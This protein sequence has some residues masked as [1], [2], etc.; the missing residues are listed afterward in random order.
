MTE[1]WDDDDGARAR[2]GTWLGDKYRLDRVLG[3]GGM[4]IVFS[5]MHRNTKRV[6]VKMLRP[7]MKTHADT[8]R[9][10]LREGYVANTVDHP[11]A[12]SVLDDD[13][14]ED[15]TAFLVMELLEGAT[16][17][18]IAGRS[19]RSMDVAAT[20][21]IAAQALD[22]LSAAHAKGIVH[23]DIKPANLFVTRSGRLKVLDFGIARL[24][25]SS[26]SQS[27]TETGTAFGTPAFMGPEQALGK[28][29]DI[30]ARTDV[31]A[32]GATMFNL[33]AGRD[34]HVG[35]NSQHV[36]VLAA[37][38][39]ARSLGSVRPDLGAP[40]VQIVDRALAFDR[41]DRWQTALAMRDAVVALH[42][43]ITGGAVGTTELVP[44]VPAPKPR[45][46][47]PDQDDLLALQSTLASNPTD[48]SSPLALPA[49]PATGDHATIAFRGHARDTAGT[50][51]RTRTPSRQRWAVLAVGAL[52][53]CVGAFALFG[54]SHAVVSPTGLSSVAPL[55]PASTLSAP[56]VSKPSA[57]APEAS[58]S[59]LT[60]GSPSAPP[61]ASIPEAATATLR[62]A[63]P[64][65]RPPS[66]PVPPRPRPP[67]PSRSSDDDFNQQ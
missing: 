61:L 37:T 67:V 19:D 47:S 5:A 42:H 29:G 30:D 24:Q 55:T 16:V 2:L 64:L 34:V 52:L 12:V 40:L 10:F 59:T 53:A 6:A 32:V 50:H 56:S 26:G 23:R 27:K 60:A 44:L 17:E 54:P 46:S 62:P 33:L 35:E 45:A 15:G 38:Q 21:N 22:T 13:V 48:V 65:P 8:Q 3:V 57:S 41:G 36:M 4:A 51:A 39:P 7:S 11:G 9:R 20:L 1:S 63:K 66:L 18:D 25:D 14:T 31:W 58:G 49:G 28:T 43:E